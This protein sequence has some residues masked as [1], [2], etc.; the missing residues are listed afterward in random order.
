MVVLEYLLET[1][2]RLQ[3]EIDWVLAAHRSVCS[4]RDPMKNLVCVDVGE[5]DRNPLGLPRWYEFGL[6]SVVERL[7]VDIVFSMTNYLP[8]RRLPCPTVLLVQH[9][10]HFSDV[11]DRL[12]RLH[13]R[14]ADRIVAWRLKPGGSDDRFEWRPEVTVQ[15]VALANAIAMRTG[16]HSCDRIHVIRH[17]PGLAGETP[18]QRQ[19]MGAQPVRIGTSRSG[20]CRRTSTCCSRQS[21]D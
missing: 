8:L 1:M 15:T 9:A 13:L 18:P 21:S 20:A 7:G 17:G 10:G 19:K 16:R 3:P 12:Q 14:R 2:A 11:F 5:I 4:S 6:P